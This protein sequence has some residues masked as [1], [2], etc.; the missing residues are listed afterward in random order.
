[1]WGRQ[2]PASNRHGLSPL[3][4]CLPNCRRGSPRPGEGHRVRPA[5]EPA[6]V[7]QK[8]VLTVQLALSQRG[9][10]PHVDAAAAGA[11]L[12]RCPEQCGS[13]A[14]VM[15]VCLLGCV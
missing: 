14:Y 6:G 7:P 11:K 15:E 13:C 2:Q 5:T 9:A 10:P 4:A 12:E 8:R 1:M 3:P